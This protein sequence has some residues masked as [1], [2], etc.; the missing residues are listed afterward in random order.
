GSNMANS[1]LSVGNKPVVVN[2]AQAA[3]IL[4]GELALWAEMVNEDVIDLRLWPR[5]FVVAERLWS[6]ADLR[7]EENM[8]ERME[9]IADWSVHALGLR[10]QQQQRAQLEQLTGT[11]NIEPLLILSGAVEP[12]HYY[13]RHHEKS[14]YG[15]Y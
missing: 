14:A 13:H 15:F 3:L 9:A 11:K 10:H 1:Q 2:Q 12:A 8:Y 5:A 4:G 6:A 7:D